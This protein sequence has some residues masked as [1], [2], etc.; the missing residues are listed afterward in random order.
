MINDLQINNK[1][2]LSFDLSSINIPECEL[3]IS[4]NSSYLLGK[5]FY[6][7]IETEKFTD[8]FIPDLKNNTMHVK[9][10]LGDTC[11]KLNLEQ[12]H[13]IKDILTNFI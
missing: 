6:I 2:E 9:N 8:I 4:E 10:E 12:F 5:N 1:E 11:I 13:H 3:I 7:P